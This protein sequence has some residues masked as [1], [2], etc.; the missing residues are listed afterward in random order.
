[1]IG[2]GINIV[3][4]ILHVIITW[5]HPQF[6]SWVR[7]TRSLVLCVSFG[8]RC[9]SFY[10]FS[11]DNCVVCSTSIYGFWLPP[12]SIFKLFLFYVYDRVVFLSGNEYARE[13]FCLLFDY[14]WIPFGDS[15]IKRESVG[16][17]LS[18]ITPSHF[19]LPFQAETWHSNQMNDSRIE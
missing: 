18:R 1:M 11:F 6:S 5:V 3:N 15:V 4:Q 8:D 19:C 10:T 13:Y 16:I 2:I 9:L 7:I 14:I 12:F 17:S